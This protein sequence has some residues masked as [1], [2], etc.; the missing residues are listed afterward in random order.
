MAP[1]VLSCWIMQGVAARLIA[2]WIFDLVAIGPETLMDIIGQ[3]AG[4]TKWLL[5][6]FGVLWG[7]DGLT[8]GLS[9]RYMGVALGQSIT[10]WLCAAVGTL[11]PAFRSGGN[12]YQCPAFKR[13][14][15]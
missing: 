8:F 9:I 14:A 12:P 5:M 6:L 2:P 3:T 15:A 4:R 10:L 7:V 1:G 11:V 13:R